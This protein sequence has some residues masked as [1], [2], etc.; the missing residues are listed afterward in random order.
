MFSR[1]VDPLDQ[2]GPCWCRALG[3]RVS[4]ERFR[5]SCVGHANSNSGF[6]GEAVNYVVFLVVYADHL[7][8]SEPFDG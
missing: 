3:T 6:G 1:E 2:P 7:V 5:V 4:S 8:R